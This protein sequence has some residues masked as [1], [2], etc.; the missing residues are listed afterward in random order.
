MKQTM[1]IGAQ[2]KKVFEAMPRQYTI[3]WFAAQI[4]C[5]RRNIYYIFERPTIDTDQLAKIS[6]ILNHNFFRDLADDYDSG[7]PIKQAP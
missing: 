6:E 3:G 4:H 1:H 7:S 2:I 5:D